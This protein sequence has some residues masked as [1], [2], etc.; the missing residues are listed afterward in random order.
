MT[1]ALA[2]RYCLMACLIAGSF[3]VLA[4]TIGLVMKLQ[5]GMDQV[6][7]TNLQNTCGK[8]YD[9]DEDG[10]LVSPTSK[11]FT[12]MMAK[13]VMSI[14]IPLGLYFGQVWFR[15]SGAGRLTQDSYSNASIWLKL[16][17]CVFGYVI[18]QLPYYT[19]EYI[20]P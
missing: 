20:D 15:Y 3:S 1:G 4:C 2:T 18:I 6:S 9:I 19:I 16:I 7:L 13:C 14:G 10:N 17:F 12:K 5:G 11:I 8:R